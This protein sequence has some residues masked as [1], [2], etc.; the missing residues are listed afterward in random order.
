MNN[1]PVAW[2][3]KNNGSFTELG[4]YS[5]ENELEEVKEMYEMRGWDYKIELLYTHPPLRELSD[6]EMQIIAERTL[7]HAIGLYN[8]KIFAKE[9]FKKA[10]EK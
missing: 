6:E 9:L 8:W 1:K 2:A 7:G 10:Q 4:Y 5:N 3:I